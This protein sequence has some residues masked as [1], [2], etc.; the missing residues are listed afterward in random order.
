MSNVCRHAKYLAVFKRRETHEIKYRFREGEEWKKDKREVRL[1]C[2][3]E[4][5]DFVGNK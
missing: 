5:G 3:K 1:L 4:H 2:K